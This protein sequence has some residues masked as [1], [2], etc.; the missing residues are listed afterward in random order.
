MF[1]SLESMPH[2]FKVQ[3]LPFLTA[4]GSGYGHLDKPKFIWF[5]KPYQ[6]ALEPRAKQRCG[7]FNLMNLSP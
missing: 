2:F 6:E 7:V 4:H 1:F 3:V 5:C